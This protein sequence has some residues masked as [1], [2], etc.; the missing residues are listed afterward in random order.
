MWGPVD[1][2]CHVTV[3]DIALRIPR[4]RRRSNFKQL[5]DFER[6][7]IVALR[8]GLSFHQIAARLSR[9]VSA[10]TNCYHAWSED[11]REQRARRSDRP[12]QVTTRQE[13]RLRL[14]AVKDRLSNTRSTAD[15]WFGE[16][17]RRI[18]KRTKSFGLTSYR[19]HFVLPLTRVIFSDESRFYLDMSDGR[20]SIDVENGNWVWQ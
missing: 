10:P 4:I 13:R 3:F 16:E 12:R 19:P 2:C 15:Q 17:G 5:S 6:G 1:D 20:R 9:T 7:R 11:G 8:E 18:T 14:L